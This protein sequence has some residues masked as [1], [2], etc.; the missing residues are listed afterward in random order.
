M[1]GISIFTPTYNRAHFLP[2]CYKSII[3][4]NFDKVE[5][6]I[7]DDGSK[8]NTNEVVSEFQSQ[9]LIDITYLYQVNSGK[10]AAWNKAVGVAKY[11]YFIG[12]D[13]DDAFCSSAL[14]KLAAMATVF[15]DE[16]IIGI[17]ALSV[18]PESKEANNS[19]SIKSDEKTSWFEEFKSGI[20]G[21]RIDLFRT[22]LLK[23]FKYPV[24]NDTKFIPEIWLYSRVSKEYQFFYSSLQVRL[25]F[26][27]VSENRLSRSKLAEHAK[28]HLLARTAL[29]EELPLKIWLYRPLDLI[30][31]LVRFYQCIWLLK[32]KHLETDNRFLRL[33]SKP[34]IFIN[35]H[36]E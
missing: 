8:D 13:S 10:Q 9:G 3:D 2:R 31:S 32:L 35:K 28:G 4:Q 20:K 36:R 27:N 25:F 18:S 12:L 33:L 5:W 34:L 26:D 15:F 16:S 30:K 7:I 24:T 14:K 29:L 11:D 17:R 22:E 6:I 21:E 23:K 1:N 19:F